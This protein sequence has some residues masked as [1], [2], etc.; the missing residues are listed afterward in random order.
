MEDRRALRDLHALMT[1]VRRRYEQLCHGLD[2]LRENTAASDDS[3]RTFR[4][5]LS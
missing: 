1:A 4:R 5:M 3:T 2:V